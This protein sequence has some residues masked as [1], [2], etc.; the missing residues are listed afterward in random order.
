MDYQVAKLGY[1]AFGV[2]R[3][4]EAVD[5]YR[6]AVRLT[7][8]EQQNGTAFLTGDSSHHWIRLDENAPLG[9]LRIGFEVVSEEALA[10]VKDA[11]TDRGISVKEN[12]STLAADRIEN[13]FRFT[14]PGG[15]EVELYTT[16]AELGAEPANNGINFK[17]FLHAVWVEPDVNV[18]HEFFS[19]VLGY[20]TSDW[21]ERRVVFM[22]CADAYHHGIAIF[23]GNESSNWSFD[24]LC[25][26]VES[27]D[28]VMRYRE[29]AKRIGV[30]VA[31]DIR[32]HAPSGSTSVYLKDPIL[33]HRVEYCVDHKQYDDK[34]E[35]PRILPG[36]PSSGNVWETPL[37][38]PGPYLLAQP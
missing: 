21:I 30:T 18:A 14:D 31:S 20:R 9:A 32:K 7:V 16:M 11:L 25:I 13:S 24:H 3:L 35:H 17:K 27:L 1:V 26:L 10:N 2:P 28:D 23:G 34:T 4:Q 33:G 6:R 12:V 37:P 38:E 8:S 15:L 29:N 36:V 19:N 5:F 22:H